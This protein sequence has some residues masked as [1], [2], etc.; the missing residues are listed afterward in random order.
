MKT[1]FRWA[2]LGL[3]LAGAQC[4]RVNGAYC[5]DV[6]PCP[7]GF[8]CDLDARECSLVSTG[9][10]GDLGGVPGD[11]A[12]CSCGGPT[13]ICVATSCVSCLSTSDG[14][15]ACAAVSPSTPYCDPSGDAAGACVGCLDNSQCSA[16]TAFCDAAT[17]ACR[18][19]IRDSECASLVCDLTPTEGSTT[20]GTCVPIAMVEY[21][22]GAAT[23]IGDGLTP[24]T[25][26]QKIQD[27]LNHATGGDK[28]PY[29]HVAA[30]TYNESNVGVTNSTSYIVGA[31]G[32][33]VAPT[34]GDA[35]SAGSNG[36][37]T[38]RNLVVTAKGGNGV[39]CQNGSF[40]AYRSQF[41]GSSQSGVYANNCNLLLDADWIDGN[42][43][44]GI[45]IGGGNFQV[46]NSIITNN[47]N[48]G[49]LY[50][51]GSGTTTAFVNNTVADNKASGTIAGVNC[52]T[53]SALLVRNS[54]LWNNKGTAGTIVAETNCSSD[55][56]A[57]DDPS[58]GPQSTIDLTIQMPGFTGTTPSSPASY[59]LASGSPCISE[60]TPMT[61]PDHD[62]D[63]E[64]RPDATTLKPDIGADELQ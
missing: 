27:A 57:S 44:G 58:A 64:P 28:R 43:G 45:Y 22:D 37:L 12:G 62:Y 11:M 38:V 5:D 9:G 51:L 60:A 30:G 23:T 1:T 31:D 10:G 33:I 48:Q 14:D 21:V 26:R 18:G 52:S 6:R 7:S 55:F 40:T 54:I 34:S 46:F 47:I 53:T 13:P 16:P 4:K 50:Q 63:L 15:G 39:N 59:H 19:C 29:V 61:A 32:A 36:S 8:A 35:L 41:V 56:D 2:A 25:P 3:L 17:H 20:R 49:G 24:T 42:S